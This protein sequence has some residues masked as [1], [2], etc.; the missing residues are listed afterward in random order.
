MI[1]DIIYKNALIYPEKKALICGDRAVTYNDLRDETEALSDLLIDYGAVSGNIIG[2]L[3]YTNIDFVI[4]M[5]SA[6][7]IGAAIAPLNSS[8]PNDAIE[9]LLNAVDAKHILTVSTLS[10]KIDP[11]GRKIIC[12]DHQEFSSPHTKPAVNNDELFILTMTSGST[13]DPKPIALSQK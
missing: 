13:G 6:A 12:I 4:A 7:H 1:T 2:V 8:L 9:R 11:N 3:L 10:K 5:L